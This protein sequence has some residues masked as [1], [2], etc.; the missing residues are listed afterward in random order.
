M[1]GSKRPPKEGD[2]NPKGPDLGLLSCFI[3]PSFLVAPQVFGQG[4]PVA[5]FQRDYHQCLLKNRP[6]F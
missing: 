4:L 6:D 5:G 2:A 1:G 3:R